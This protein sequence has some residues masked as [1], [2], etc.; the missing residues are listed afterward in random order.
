MP[1][2]HLRR[3]PIRENYFNPKAILP[4]GLRLSEVKSSLEDAH[5]FIYSLN[6]MLYRQTAQR[7]EDILMPATFSGM[8]S[9]FIVR[10]LS[11]HSTTLTRNLYHNGHPDLIPVNH[12]P[13]NA[14]Q[15]GHEGVEIKTSRY[16]SSWQGHNPEKVWIMVFRYHS[17]PHK[18]ERDTKPME[19][20]TP[21]QIVTVLTAELDRNDW[22]AQGRGSGSRRTP[23]A[24]II[25]SGAAKLRAN[26][27]YRTPDFET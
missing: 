21:F 14:V 11:K 2:A 23:T 10:Q 26:W 12:Y 16:A 19:E 9:E 4:Y 22:S 25:L 13:G 1:K 5:V 24:S 17:D 15:Y 7:I 8:L 20:R 18:P 27:I 6:K 3:I